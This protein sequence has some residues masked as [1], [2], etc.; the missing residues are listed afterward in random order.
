MES[1]YLQYS[2]VLFLW[3]SQNLLWKESLTNIHY[4]KEDTLSDDSW[5]QACR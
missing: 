3:A 4:V 5:L 2:C 1:D